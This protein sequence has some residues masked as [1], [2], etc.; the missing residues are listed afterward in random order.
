MHTSQQACPSIGHSTPKHTH[1]HTLTRLHTNALDRK[2]NC[3]IRRTDTHTH[4]RL[5]GQFTPT[6]AISHKAAECSLFLLTVTFL[7]FLNFLFPPSS[8]SLCLFLTLHVSVSH[9]LWLIHQ[10]CKWTAERSPKGVCSCLLSA[11]QYSRSVCEKLLRVFSY[12]WK[13]F[14]FEAFGT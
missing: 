13:L 8:L 9:P 4:T 3:R 12:F 10:A 2:I 6:H 14:T 7:S 11:H 5:L 1:T